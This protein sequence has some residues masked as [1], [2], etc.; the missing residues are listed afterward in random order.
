MLNLFTLN[1]YTHFK[2]KGAFIA[3]VQ[4]T[5][6]QVKQI[7]LRVIR[8][9]KLTQPEFDPGSAALNRIPS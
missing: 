7:A 5:K 4:L 2:C 9:Q 8:L 3:T 1:Y 6:C